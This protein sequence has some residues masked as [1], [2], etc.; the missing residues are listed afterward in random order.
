MDKYRQANQKMWDEFVGINSRSDLYELEAFK[1]GKNK[2][3][4]LETSEVG[5]VK[6]KSLLHLQCHF[7]MDTLSWAR[8][9]ADVTGMDFSPRGIE[10]ARSL[11][12]EL[13][14]SARFICCDL[15]DLPNQLDRKF[16][17]VF[18]SYGVLCWLPDIPR[19][20]RI[21]ASFLQQGGFFYM[22]EFHPFASVFDNDPGIIGWKL[23]YPYFE[24]QAMEFEADGS[25]ADPVTKIPKMKEYEWEHGMGEVI[26]SLVDAGL[27]IDFLHEFPYT[28]F[29]AFPFLEKGN[30]GYW[31]QPG[32]VDMIPL[33]YTI[34]ATK[35]V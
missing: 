4:P 1:K 3:N 18:T 31:H 34:K 6:G 5:D 11:S 10:L 27:R 13:N 12:E 26:T 32:G 2:L 15:Y 8:L 16:D 25:Y 29:S 14:I 24:R 28:C 19:W 7:G 30:D 23:R 33:T 22:A 17:I 35:L 20:A 21:A 9:G